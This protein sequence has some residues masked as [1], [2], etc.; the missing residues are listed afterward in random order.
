MKSHYQQLINDTV[1]EILETKQYLH[2]AAQFQR[3]VH[4][5]DVR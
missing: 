5:V 1:A 3:L 2:I 4:Q